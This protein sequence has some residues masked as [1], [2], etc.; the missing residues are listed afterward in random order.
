MKVQVNSC[1]V[2]VSV[3]LVLVAHDACF[4]WEVNHNI[5]VASE[6]VSKRP[7]KPANWIDLVE[8]LSKSFSTE[9]K[10]VQLKGR[11]CKERMDLLIKKY[12]DDDKKSLKR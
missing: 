1:N 2:S 3:I 4:R 12:K 5:A 9:D 10:P 7:Q 11:G 8:V 6:V